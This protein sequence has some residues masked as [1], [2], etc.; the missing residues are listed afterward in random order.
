VTAFPSERIKHLMHVFPG[1]SVGGSQSRF[2]QLVKGAA[3]Q[4]YRHTVLSLDGRTEMAG[5]LPNRCGVEVIAPVIPKGSGLGTWARCRRQIRQLQ[6]DVLVTYNWGSMD[7]CIANLLVPL[8]RH[9]HIEDGFGPEEKWRQL[10]RRVWTRRI[11]LSGRNS[12]VVVPS[13]TLERLARE[14]WK[15]PEAN[16]KYI[17]NGVDS[18]RFGGRPQPP[19]E[20]RPLVLGTVAT[21]R[22]EKNLGRMIR[23]FNVLAAQPGVPALELVIVGDG[24]ERARLEEAA[25]RSPFPDKIR[26]TGASSTPE[27]ELQKFDIFALTSDTEQMPLSVLEAMACALPVISFAV[28]DVPQMVAPENQAFVRIPLQDDAGFIKGLRQ[29]TSSPSLRASLG[30]ANRS[31]ALK[32]FDQGLMLKR[33]LELFG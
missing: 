4:R 26:F 3:E 8:A 16:L 29:L 21:L 10:R 19:R 22:A 32:H 31:W 13:H 28:G 1:F 23:L 7:W 25:R 5:H 20:G 27:V 11:A 6:P 24:P 33:H 14:D 18:V 9:I 17:P 12:V 2:V 30:E 15:I